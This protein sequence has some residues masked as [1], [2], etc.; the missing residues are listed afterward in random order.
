MVE[1]MLGKKSNRRPKEP[2]L[3][4]DKAT[5]A[6]SI[7]RLTDAACRL[8]FYR[9]RCLVRSMVLWHLLTGQGL[10]AKLRFGVRKNGK[11]LKAH[12]W[13]EHEGA[14]LGESADLYSTYTPLLDPTA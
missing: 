1:S 12:A 3:N 14:A 7:V 6:K 10:D 13:V 11:Q 5:A 8:P 2:L 9:F 4:P